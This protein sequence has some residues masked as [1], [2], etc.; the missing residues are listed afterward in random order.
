MLIPPKKEKNGK[1]VYVD[2]E[3]QSDFSKT[4][5]YTADDIPFNTGW[6]KYL[7]IVG[8]GDKISE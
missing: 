1:W 7:D 2:G 3:P 5:I 6:K 4:Q 8:L